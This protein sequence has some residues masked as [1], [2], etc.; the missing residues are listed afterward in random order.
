MTPSLHPLSAALRAALSVGVFAAKPA[1]HRPI[2]PVMSLKATNAAS[3]HYELLIYGDI[4]ETWWGTSVLAADVVEQLNALPATVMQINV[5]INSYGGSVSDGLAIYYA[6]K[7]MAATKVVTVD[8]VAMSIAS[9]IA[10]AGDTIEMPETAMLMIHAPWGLCQGNS[11]DMRTFADFLDVYANAMAYAYVAKSGLSRE[12]VMALLTDGQDHVYTAAQAR[13]AGFCDALIVIAASNDDTNASEQATAFFAGMQRFTERMPVHATAIR[14][15]V[16]RSHLLAPTSV[17]AT[18]P[19]AAATPED[20]DMLR[21]ATARHSPHVL[22]EQQ[23]DPADGSVRAGTP[24]AA[25]VAAVSPAADPSVANAAQAAVV[26]LRARNDTILATLRPHLANRAI[27]ELQTQ[28]LADPALSLDQVNQ[29]AMAI[30]G[31]QATPNGADPGRIEAGEDQ[32]DKRRTAATRILLVRAGSHATRDMN[33]G[34]IAAA[35]QG[36]P[37]NGM[38][39]LEIA[40]ACCVNAGLNPSGWNKNEIVAAAITHSTSDFP[41]VFENVLHKVLINSYLSIDQSWRNFCK[42]GTLADFRPHNRYNFG[43][44]SDLLPVDETGEYQDGTLNDAEK[45]VIQGQSKGRILN[46][47]R[48]MIINDD[49]GVFTGAASKLGQAAGRTIAKDVYGLFALNNGLGP[50]MND[51]KPLFDTA[52][53][54]ISA[55]AAPVGTESFDDMRVGMGSQLDPAGNDF[56]EITP[57]IWLGPLKYKGDA[58]VVN[59]SKYNVDVA[60][61]FE[62][63]NKSYGLVSQ[64]IGSPRLPGTA[65]YG[66]ANPDV[67][68]V[69]E[70]AFLDGVQEP[71]VAMEESFR[72]NG[73]AWRVLYDYAVGAVG[74]RGAWLNKGESE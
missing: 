27:A 16:R 24:A 62:I 50:T 73:I 11:S 57:A 28:A 8:G 51:G 26:A 42:I 29:K 4:G 48:E 25:S 53:R 10:M 3:T 33:A 7:R 32:R 47:S 66:F 1:A 64:V 30:L 52:H 41:H 44:F 37:F 54:N 46:L 69:L 14:A 63:P 56:L 18:P 9:L 21:R 35:R 19:A 12:A 65:W 22:R 40:R 31:A 68:A 2:A 45:E 58:D 13:D 15:A 6:L 60:S 59:G 61:K 72:S 74:F 70:A 17:G 20:L 43:G 36:N 49:L 34:E 5:R 55:T 67:E 39:L 71:Q 38:T 23:N